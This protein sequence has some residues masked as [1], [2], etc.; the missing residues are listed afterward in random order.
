M[1][2]CTVSQ[3]HANNFI[4]NKTMEVNMLLPNEVGDYELIPKT[5]LVI[6]QSKRRVRDL[7]NGGIYLS[8]KDLKKNIIF[9]TITTY[10]D[11]HSDI[12]RNNAVKLLEHLDAESFLAIEP[13]QSLL[14]LANEDVIQEKSDL[15]AKLVVVFCDVTGGLSRKDLWGNE[16]LVFDEILKLWKL[17]GLETIKLRPVGKQHVEFMVVKNS[18]IVSIVKDWE[19][20]EYLKYLGMV[21]DVRVV[22]GLFFIIQTMIEKCYGLSQTGLTVCKLINDSLANIIF[23]FE[24]DNPSR[25]VAMIKKLPKMS[26]LDEREQIP[27]WIAVGLEKYVSM[28]SFE[29][30]E[31]REFPELYFKLGK[32]DLERL[33]DID[34]KLRFPYLKVLANSDVTDLEQCVQKGLEKKLDKINERLDLLDSKVFDLQQKIDK[35]QKE[36]CDIKEIIESNDVLCHKM[37][38]HINELEQYSRSNSIRIFG[39]EKQINEK[40]SETICKFSKQKLNIDLQPNCIE[41]C[42]PVG[43]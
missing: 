8:Q 17:V 10:M 2:I 3:N 37:L 27:T 42:H 12:T 25:F 19:E 24:K 22:G 40:L 36:V 31:G 13:F 28:F 33:K 29:K 23:N 34:V 14:L 9:G 38:T 5:E 15:V 6:F 20:V 16:R 7:I 41:R 39:I 35:Y 18:P 11:F 32:E 26:D 30:K 43:N 4:N 21:F 1:H